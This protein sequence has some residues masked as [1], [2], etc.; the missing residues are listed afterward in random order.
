MS[1]P[2]L[3][4]MD[5]S[6]SFRMT[7]SGVCACPMWF[8]RLERHAARERRVADDAPP[9]CSVAAPAGRAPSPG[10]APPTASRRH[11]PRDARRRGSRRASGN[12]RGRR[13][14]A[15]CLNSVQPAGDQLVRIG[16]VPHVEHQ[17]VARA[18]KQ[19]VHGQDDLHRAQRRAPR[20][21]PSPTS[22][23]HDLL[24]YLAGQGWTAP[25]CPAASG[26]P[27]TRSR[28]ECDVSMVTPPAPRLGR[29]RRGRLGVSGPAASVSR[30]RLPPRPR[31]SIGRVA[32]LVFRHVLVLLPGRRCS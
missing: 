19:A 11:G 13:R 9:P 7:T 21:R 4:E 27:A 12:P 30:L 14:C 10:R 26:R 6:L 16:L 8:E 18:I 1:A 31:G 15:A 3:R 25:R 24:A 17:L 2:T 28:R 32:P 23:C 20:A 5:I 29:S 22:P